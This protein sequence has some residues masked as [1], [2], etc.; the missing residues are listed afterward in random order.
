MNP[1]TYLIR[2]LNKA[3][4]QAG[5]PAT[6]PQVSASRDPQFGDFSTNLALTLTK[7]IHRKPLDIAEQIKTCLNLDDT[8]IRRV[9]VTSPGFI[10]FFINDDYYR[11]IIRLILTKRERFGR[12]DSG[13]GKTANVEFVSANPTG[14]L[15]VGHGRQA[16]IG[17]TVANILEW[18]GYAVTREYYYNDAGRQMRLLGQSV[19]TR[20]FQELG[21][22]IEL[23]KDGYQGNYLREIA[24][25]IRAEQGDRLVAGDPVFRK[26]AEATIFS[27]IKQ[28]LASLGIYHK[29]FANE[30]DYYESG[31]VNQLVADLK[32]NN[33]VY[34]SEGATWFKTTALGKKQDRVLIKGSGEPT[35]RL[36]DMAYHRDK[37]ERKFD[38][39]IDLFGADHTDTYPDVLAALEA[40]GYN[41]QSIKVLIHQ[42]VTL[43]RSGEKVKM[44]TRKAN[45]VTLEELVNLVG[46]DVV[47]YFFIMRG[48]NSHLNFDLDLAED[49]S[50][51]N[52]VYY[53]QYAHARICNIIKHGE[54]MGIQFK[55]EFNPALLVHPTEISLLKMLTEFPAT[56]VAIL[57]SLE[58]QTVTTYLQNLAAL[59]HKFYT[60]CKVITDDQPLTQA[61]LALI[62]AIKIVLSSG[63]TEI[64]GVKAPEKM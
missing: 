41:I 25:E 9:T 56:V 26:A 24:Q 52:P 29:R 11:N 46:A 6:S 3:L 39:I 53:L 36:P 50:E 13:T 43:V 47:R 59:F 54:S 19:E 42:F 27:D 63:L 23:P 44:S 7:K 37:L 34:E 60:E 32:S 17:D 45:F 55:Q 1:K 21:Q 31:A 28:S 4:S 64:L 62:S 30:K 18:H 58:P 35:Y 12:G 40:L 8:I 48:M 14:P 33:L 38:L 57:K 61:R 22:N 15:T 20:Y 10:N 51:K 16:V 5:L 2:Q 49:E